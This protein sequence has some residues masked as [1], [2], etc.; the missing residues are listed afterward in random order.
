MRKFSKITSTDLKIEEI[1]E[2]YLKHVTQF[3]NH[4]KII[5]K[6]QHIQIELHE[7]NYL[8][9]HRKINT[10][11]KLLLKIQYLLWYLNVTRNI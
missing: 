8:L 5:I 1:F 7:I 9:N 6:I 11:Y 3:F 10:V 2:T 4:K